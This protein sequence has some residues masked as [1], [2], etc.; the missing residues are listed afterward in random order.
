MSDGKGK[1]LD[2]SNGTSGPLK[3]GSAEPIP[4]KPDADP[5]FSGRRHHPALDGLRGLA[6]IMVMLLHYS[7]FLP[8]FLRPLL[9]QGG[10]GVDLFFVLSGFLITG[11]LH[12]AKGQDHYFRNFYA[13]RF[14]RIFPLYYGVLSVLLISLLIFRFG[15]PGIWAHK[16][17]APLLWSYQPW[18]WTY[19]AN[20]YM[21]MHRNGM[22]MLLHFWSLSIEEQFYLVWPLVVF[23]LSR[24]RLIRVCTGAIAGSLILRLVLAAAG[25]HFWTIANLTPCRLDSL[26]AGAAL[27]LMLRNTANIAGLT[28]AAKRIAVISLIIWVLA[29]I[30]PA[31]MIQH[32]PPSG[33]SLTPLIAALLR[34]L[35]YTL[36]AM[37]FASMLMLAVDGKAFGGVV[38]G[39][40]GYKVLRW[41]GRYSYGI[42]VFHFPVYIASGVF[43]QDDGLW[44]KIRASTGLGIGF[45]AAN[46]AVSISLAFASFHLYEKHFLKLKKYFPEKSV[47]LADEAAVAQAAE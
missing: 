32:F 25:F 19:T 10:S 1:N 44:G 30:S 9:R 7:P 33:T 40:F 21:A 11:I 20:F 47:Q 34:E 8:N 17:L 29:L 28:C 18:L 39:I 13:R 4:A 31:W 2:A 43:L 41:F 37:V 42:Y 45:V 14:L 24:K 5:F 35:P 27:A 36:V 38:A 26:A 22:F 16:H 15:F 23:S 12:D 46:A 3:K 6:I